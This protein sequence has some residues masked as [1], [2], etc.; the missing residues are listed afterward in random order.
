M[1]RFP[2]RHWS[3]VAVLLAAIVGTGCAQTDGA[4]DDGDSGFRELRS[5]QPHDMAP[6]VSP[7]DY[8]KVVAGT[9]EF[10]L[11]LLHKLAPADANFFYSPVS[12][13]LALGMTYAGARGSTAEQMALVLGSTVPPEAF[14]SSMNRLM[15]DLAARNVA[16]HE[17]KEGTKSVTLLPANAVWMQ[18]GMGL[19]PG[20][21]DTMSVRYDAGIKVLDLM[22]DPRGSTR[23]VNRWVAAHTKDKILDLL[24]E[25]AIDGQ[26]PLV[27]TNALY[28]YGSWQS[29]FLT[30]STS[31]ATFHAL[32]DVDVTVPMMH[33]DRSIPY[34]E[35]DGYQ[36][37]DLAYDG[38]QLSMSVLLPAAG[39]FQEIRD[40]ITQATLESMRSAMTRDGEVRLALPKFR[41]TWGTESFKNQLIA[42][43]M[44]DAFDGGRADFSGIL[45]GGGLFID[46][47]MHKAFIGVD[48]SGTEAAAAT[49]VTTRIVSAPVIRHELTAD[50]PFLIFIRDATGALLFAGQVT[51]PSL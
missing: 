10:G 37:I 15:V 50:R 36:L 20:Y 33:D 39:R 14:A 23:T 13:A 21:L 44:V 28:F 9:T 43:G 3:T 32:A 12:T 2:E 31:N 1:K 38:G 25:G 42:M 18:K 29:P 46:D 47:V 19:G 49:A 41:F 48:E 17:T 11:S 27:L 30:S 45:P 6:T 8:A 35:G 34:A 4:E 16:P 40:G 5:A 24:P 51:N 7:D 22:G 26:T